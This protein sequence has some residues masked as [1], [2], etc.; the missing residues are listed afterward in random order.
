M[1]VIMRPQ[2]ISD[3]HR[4]ELAHRSVAAAGRYE[5]A[6][7]AKETSSQTI[8]R[9]H[10]FADRLVRRHVPDLEMT[11]RSVFAR[12]IEGDEPFSVL[13]RVETE[14]VGGFGERMFHRFAHRFPLSGVV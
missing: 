13:A 12:T 14:I 8:H 4:R 5:K 1:N 10:R 6:I 7:V 11:L 3:F 2:G 9:H